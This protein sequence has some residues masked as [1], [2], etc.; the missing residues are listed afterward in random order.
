MTYFL[1]SKNCVLCWIRCWGEL[2]SRV[3]AGGWC[4]SV[5]YS[6]KQNKKGGESLKV[7]MVCLLW[8]SLYATR[9]VL[10]QKAFNWK[11]LWIKSSLIPEFWQTWGKWW[12]QL[13]YSNF[14][15]TGLLWTETAS[16]IKLSEF[17]CYIISVIHDLSVWVQ[18]SF[19]VFMSASLTCFLTSLICSHCWTN[20]RRWSLVFNSWCQGLFLP[21]LDQHR[22][23][24]FIFLL[25]LKLHLGWV[26][27]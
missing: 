10:R 18:S 5:V 24:Y 4:D 3:S 16:S 11:Q 6:K 14:D 8:F 20:Q 17:K 22:R 2:L 21:P 13:N 1:L 7:K 26:G 19:C 23:T 15:E 25:H 9:S 12:F 27:I